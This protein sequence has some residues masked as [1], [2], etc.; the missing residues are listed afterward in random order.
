MGLTQNPDIDILLN[1][2]IQPLLIC[3]DLRISR[4]NT[5]L[6]QL[7][8]IEAAPEPDLTDLSELL[9]PFQRT[10][11]E[12]LISILQNAARQG[13][14]TEIVFQHADGQPIPAE[15]RVAAVSEENDALRLLNVSDLRERKRIEAE[16][17]EHEIRLQQLVSELQLAEERTRSDLATVLHDQISHKLALARLD[18]SDLP[19]QQH[20]ADFPQSVQRIKT[21][22]TE[23]IRDTRA[24]MYD[25]SPPVLHDLGLLEA[26]RWLADNVTKR[27]RF[28]MHLSMP[29]STPN[30][31]YDVTIMAFRSIQELFNN[32][33]KHAECANAYL[34]LTVEDDIVCIL[35]RD[36]GKG[37]N[38]NR[39]FAEM[40]DSHFG[41]SNLQKRVEYMGGA[42]QLESAPGN[43][44]SVKILL[45]TSA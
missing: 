1:G 32:I 43:G 6:C 26:L 44:T 23:A 10:T 42:V 39:V 19:N 40:Q 27:G 3:R 21:L 14:S 4:C 5:A 29:E 41:F 35:V 25:L 17:F 22:I 34:D 28:Q 9:H 37:F 2:I 33:I 36:D 45:R 12:T 38:V 20:D 31:S 11:A 15:V 30:L 7:L 24:L 18:L 16:F 8:G 13:Q